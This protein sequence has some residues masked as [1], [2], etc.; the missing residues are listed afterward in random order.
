MADLKSSDVGGELLAYVVTGDASLPIVPANQHRW[1]MDRTAEGFA[2]R[3]LPLLMANQAGWFLLNS[4]TI[5]AWWDGGPN[6]EHVHIQCIDGPATPCPVGSHFGHGILTWSVPYLFRTP[7]GWNLLVR[8]PANWPKDGIAAL[9]GLVETDFSIATFT[10]NW[11]FTRPR[12]VVRFG[13]GEPIAMLV[14]QRRG[15]LETF[16]PEM[17][18]LGTDPELQQQ[19]DAWRARRAQFNADLQARA[20]E[21]CRRK[22]EKEYF[23]GRFAGCPEQPAHQT[24]LA[25]APF[26]VV[27]PDTP[28][29]A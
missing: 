29:A 10:M 1:W 15:E 22:W 28:D 12:Q 5:E 17:R 4:H 7:P 14:P 23:K 18:S 21:A 3:C 19:H 8:G 25:L 27:Q 2:K 16:Q 26:R 24:K 6:L 13:V 20:P 11:K 9:E